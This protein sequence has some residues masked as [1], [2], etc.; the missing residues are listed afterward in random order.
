MAP[1]FHKL[2]A[3]H[4]LA[5][6]EFTFATFHLLRSLTERAAISAI[7][8]VCIDSDR[9]RAAVKR[10]AAFSKD[11]EEKARRSCPGGTGASVCRP[12]GRNN[13]E[14]TNI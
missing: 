5:F 11:M 3:L 7:E 2:V 1:S 6:P 13:I 14:K 9:F 8:F 4:S 12:P 10:G